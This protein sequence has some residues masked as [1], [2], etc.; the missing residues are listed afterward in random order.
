MQPLESKEFLALN[1]KVQA[2]VFWKNT[3]IIAHGVVP[4]AQGVG[5]IKKELSHG[6][7]T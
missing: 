5:K 4:E 1:L 2:F 7:A 6:V 3:L